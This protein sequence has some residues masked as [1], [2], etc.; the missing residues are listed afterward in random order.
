VSSAEAF[1]SIVQERCYGIKIFYISALQVA[2][3]EVL[4]QIWNGI[5]PKGETKSI[6]AFL[7]IA[8]FIIEYQYYS[9]LSKKLCIQFKRKLTQV[10]RVHRNM[11]TI[12]PYFKVILAYYA[13]KGSIRFYVDHVTDVDVKYYEVTCLRKS[14]D[15]GK[16]FAFPSK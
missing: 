9:F 7:P 12:L 4:D 5:V 16:I 15:N 11:N 10:G 2:H 8:P 3:Q 13:G 14:G 1:A 6:H